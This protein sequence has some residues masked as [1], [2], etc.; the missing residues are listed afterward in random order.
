MTHWRLSSARGQSLGSD[1][2]GC[3][4]ISHARNFRRIVVLGLGRSMGETMAVTMVGR[5]RADITASAFAPGATM[6]SV[7]ANEYPE[8]STKLYLSGANSGWY[9]FICRVSDSGSD[10]ARLVV[11]RFEK[12]DGAF[13]KLRNLEYPCFT[14]SQSKKLRYAGVDHSDT[15]FL[16][17]VVP[18]FCCL[19]LRFAKRGSGFKSFFLY[20]SARSQQVKPVGGIENAIF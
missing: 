20:K 13:M 2:S 14:T 5:N 9:E 3:S 6:A 16:L 8:A 4:A 10:F 19:H 1:P 18:L 15:T 7:I 12:E 11:Y 17:A